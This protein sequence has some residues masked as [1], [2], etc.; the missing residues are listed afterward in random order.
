MR[1]YSS[2]LSR[3]KARGIAKAKAENKAHNGFETL[4]L[5]L[6][7]N[8]RRRHIVRLK[9]AE[10]K[11]IAIPNLGA[12]DVKDSKVLVKLLV[13]T[14]CI[15][16]LKIAALKKFKLNG[17]ILFLKH[18]SRDSS[19]QHRIYFRSIFSCGF[20]DLFR[21]FKNFR[22]IALRSA[23]EVFLYDHSVPCYAD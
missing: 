10:A 11:P 23:P 9:A 18:F 16:I 20:I 13:E 4:I 12:I 5:P 22:T 2:V 6:L 7:R 3:P 1:I 17:A 8:L 14:A 21:Y 15:A 19:L